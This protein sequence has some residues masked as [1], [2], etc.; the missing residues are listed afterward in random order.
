MKDRRGRRYLLHGADGAALFSG[1]RAMA[2][3]RVEIEIERC[4]RLHACLAGQHFALGKV[5][6]RERLVV[7]V[8]LGVLPRLTAAL[9]GGTHTFAAIQRNL[10]ACT[11]RRIKQH[12][13]ALN[14]AEQCFPS[15]KFKAT[16]YVMMGSPP[17]QR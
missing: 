16:L 11:Q 9:T 10:D 8:V 4:I 14:G 13:V 5:V 17:C 7:H 2:E 3:R 15:A 6:G 12:F 1:I